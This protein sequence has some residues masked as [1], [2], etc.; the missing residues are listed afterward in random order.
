MMFKRHQSAHFCLVVARVRM[1]HWTG[2]PANSSV[3]VAPHFQTVNA[4]HDNTSGQ[5]QIR[6]YGRGNVKC[7]LL[8]PFNQRVDLLQC[9]LHVEKSGWPLVWGGDFSTCSSKKGCS[10]GVELSVV[11]KH[12]ILPKEQSCSP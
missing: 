10:Y 5:W 12:Y 2:Q 6:G 11:V 8:L 3:F 9:N 7:V 4:A 1:C